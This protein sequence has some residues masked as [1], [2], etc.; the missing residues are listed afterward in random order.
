MNTD[1]GRPIAYGRTAE[2]F[3]WQEGQVLKLFHEW[4]EPEDVEYEARIAHAIQ[5]CGLPVPAVG[6]IIQINGRNGLLYQRVYG[7]PLSKTL[8]HKP[9]LIFA[10][11]RRT[12]EL[13]AE[14]HSRSVQAAIPPQRQKLLNKIRHAE[15]LPAELRNKALAALETMPDGDRLCH[16]DFQPDNIMMTRQGE[17]VI[18][19]I[20]ASTGNPLADIA[21]STILAL[22]AAD[23]QTQSSIEKTFVR[24]FTS[25][26][27]HYYFKFRPGGE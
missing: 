8:S 15:A 26:Y 5:D 9:W 7:D 25:S 24:M 14:M 27:I 6:D 18:D 13:H 2:I 11:A 17:V 3:A 4:V 16:G 10:C 22:G 23:C 1:L 12:A 20:D 21:R 19:W